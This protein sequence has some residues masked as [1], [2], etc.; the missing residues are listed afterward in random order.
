M[1]YF[2]NFD[3]RL[4]ENVLSVAVAAAMGLSTVPASAATSINLQTI[5]DGA[6]GQGPLVL[7]NRGFNWNGTT[8]ISTSIV[9]YA[10]GFF[11]VAENGLS[12]S[13]VISNTGSLAAT[14][15]FVFD[16]GAVGTYLLPLSPVQIVTTTFHTTTIAGAN[17]ETN[18]S[19]TL[20]LIA[21]VINPWLSLHGY[22][23]EA[24][25]RVIYRCA[26]VPGCRNR[27]TGAT[28]IRLQAVYR[29]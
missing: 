27:G 5:G 22:L 24:D 19:R 25:S 18:P 21:L 28:E 15:D 7:G 16:F 11:G 2:E 26:D 29:S 6:G 17:L 23:N 4:E 12:T 14:D 1:F 3:E 10:S 8:C 20:P 9:L 13:A